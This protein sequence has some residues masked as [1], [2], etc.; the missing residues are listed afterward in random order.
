MLIL[1]NPVNP[2]IDPLRADGPLIY[3]HRKHHG[4]YE[5]TI[6][7]KVRSIHS[8]LSSMGTQPNQLPKL[9]NRLVFDE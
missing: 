5:F 1:L 6:A 4:D 7:M 3:T 2:A 9:S 8:E